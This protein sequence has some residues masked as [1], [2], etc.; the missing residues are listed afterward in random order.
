[1]PRAI[2]S[3]GMQT[4]LCVWCL[5]FIAACCALPELLLHAQTSQPTTQPF[6]DMPLVD[7]LAAANEGNADA[8]MNLAKRYAIGDGTGKDPAAALRW[9]ERAAEQGRPEAEM[10]LGLIYGR[11]F[12]VPKDEAEGMRWLR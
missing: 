10:H 4:L 1:M 9:Y 7:V 11:G 8:Q 12:G 6:A 3:Q 5:S 2:Q